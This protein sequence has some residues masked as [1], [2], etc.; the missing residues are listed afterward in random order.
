MVSILRELEI[1]TRTLDLWEDPAL[2]I[3]DGDPQDLRPRV[4]IFE[5]LDRPDLATAAL[6]AVRR[7]PHFDPVGAL[8]A[9]TD[10]QI[11]N[12]SPDSGFDDF[13]RY[14]Y[15][16]E[17]LQARLLAIEWRRAAVPAA[18]QRSYGRL[19]IDRSGH[20]VYVDGQPIR[21]THRE[22]SLVVYFFDRPGMAL[23][24]DQLLRAVWGHDYQGDPQTVDVHVSRLRQKLGDAFL[25]ETLRGWGGYRMSSPN[26]DGI[27][28][29]VGAR[30][31][32][33]KVRKHT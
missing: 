21:L 24:R 15:V 29:A 31:K 30:P 9:V 23:T 22:F 18:S 17:E 5:A 6:E 16:P 28:G 14:P 27:G 13:V 19:V 8:I 20:D 2:L 1:P 26:T 32:K 3:H 4:L 12:L 33:M 10:Q 25:I 11:A 7:V